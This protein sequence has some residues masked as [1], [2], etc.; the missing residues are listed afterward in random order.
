[1]P[2]REFSRKPLTD[3]RY[4]LDRTATERLNRRDSRLFSRLTGIRTDIAKGIVLLA[5]DDAGCMTG[6]GLVVD[7]G[8]TAQ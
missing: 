6:A 7:G 3:Q 1:M 4:F 5:S 8:I 2:R